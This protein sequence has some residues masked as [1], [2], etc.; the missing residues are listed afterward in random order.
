MY[1][2]VEAGSK[3]YKVEV[4][5]VIDVETTGQKKGEEAVFDRVLLAVK[6]QDVMIGTPYLKSP[7]VK[8]VVEDVIK[9]KKVI[10]FKYKRKTGYHR[11]KGHRQ[12]YTRIRIESIS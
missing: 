7:L 12:N 8:G 3:Q 11:T 2:I 1:A 4:G 10:C 9:D 5:S 6:D